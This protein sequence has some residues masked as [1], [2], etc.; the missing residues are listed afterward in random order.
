MRFIGV[1]NFYSIELSQ[2]GKESGMVL[3]LQVLRAEN[4]KTLI[5]LILLSQ[6]VNW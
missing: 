2:S 6:E 3:C 1:V 4:P 5:L